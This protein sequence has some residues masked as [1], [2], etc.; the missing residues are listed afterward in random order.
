MVNYL[1]LEMYTEGMGSDNQVN[2]FMLLKIIK[3]AIKIR[4]GGLKY[5]NEAVI[6]NYDTRVHFVIT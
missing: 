3:I 4:E 5:I 2:F 6:V 1:N